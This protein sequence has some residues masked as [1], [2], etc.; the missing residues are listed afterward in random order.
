[1]KKKN[2]D[3]TE[4]DQKKLDELSKKK[5]IYEQKQYMRV[6]AKELFEIGKILIK[7]ESDEEVKGINFNKRQEYPEDTP[8][9]FKISPSMITYEIS[10]P[11]HM[12]EKIKN[13]HK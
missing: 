2:A 6:V 12:Y 10:I 3:W 7:A 13:Q 8:F 11:A 5:R 4:E 9:I 1:M